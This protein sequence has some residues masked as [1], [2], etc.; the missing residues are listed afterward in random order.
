ME[1][2]PKCGEYIEFHI[3]YSCGNPVIYYTCPQC[4][5]DTRSLV[6]TVSTSTGKY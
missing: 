1:Q 2:C 3:E 6:V 4:G 5:Y